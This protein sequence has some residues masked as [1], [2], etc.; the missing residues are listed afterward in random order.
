MCLIFRAGKR[1]NYSDFRA[2]TSTAFP[3]KSNH[4]C[5]NKSTCVKFWVKTFKEVILATNFEL[6]HLDN[7][8][9]L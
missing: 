6:H 4:I 3:I 7:I 2:K 5:P 1:E 8:S 9:S